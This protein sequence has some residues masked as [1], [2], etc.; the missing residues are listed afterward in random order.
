MVQLG[1]LRPSHRKK[2]ER[3]DPPRGR[4]LWYMYKTRKWMFKERKDH[5]KL[6]EKGKAL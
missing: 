6:K 3:K 1:R 5:S 2:N 4:H